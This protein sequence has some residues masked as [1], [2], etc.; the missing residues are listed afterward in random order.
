MSRYVQNLTPDDQSYLDRPDIAPVVFPGWAPE[1]RFGTDIKRTCLLSPGLLSGIPDRKSRNAP[2]IRRCD[3]LSFKRIW[4]ENSHRNPDIPGL[5][6]GY[7]K[8]DN[9]PD[10]RNAVVG[11]VQYRTFRVCLKN[12]TG[13]VIVSTSD[14]EDILNLCLHHIPAADHT[15][16]PQCTGSFLYNDSQDPQGQNGQVRGRGVQWLLFPVEME[17]T[18]GLLLYLQHFRQKI[19]R[20]HGQ[21]RQATKEQVLR[22]LRVFGGPENYRNFIQRNSEALRTVPEPGGNTRLPKGYE[23]LLDE[24]LEGLFNLAAS[25][26][27]PDPLPLTA[28]ER[29]EQIILLTAQTMQMVQERKAK[30][31]ED[32]KNLFK[33][34]SPDILE[35]RRSAVEQC[36]RAL[37][38][39]PSMPRSVENVQQEVQQLWDDHIPGPSSSLVQ[40]YS[41]FR[42]PD[43]SS[44]GEVQRHLATNAIDS[45]LDSIQASTISGGD[46]GPPSDFDEQPD[47]SQ[48]YCARDSRRPALGW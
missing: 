30:E 45:V 5:L 27:V 23:T 36:S 37:Y 35:A 15:E 22:A 44:S 11:I 41:H 43:P 1:A 48:S 2:R 10:I 31:R 16:M 34:V 42:G 18:F 32:L 24:E 47:D 28:D 3:L 39:N 12:G 9:W 38:H 29:S 26:D 20:A 6:R 14:I 7:W 19:I 13:T 46:Y 4:L 8:I 40:Y 25:I 21:Q 33:N 17:G